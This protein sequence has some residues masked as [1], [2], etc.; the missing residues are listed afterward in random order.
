MPRRRKEM[1]VWI[2][3]ARTTKWTV[4]ID[5]TD[6]S[7]YILSGSFTRGLIGEDSRCEIELDNSGENY[8]DFFDIGD[9]IVFKMDFSNGSTVQWQGKVEGIEDG[10]T[11]LFKLKITGNHL[12]AELLDVTVTEEYANAKVSDILKD[13]INKYLN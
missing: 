1:F 12:T 8:T 10:L 7:D 9:D 4:T 2:P 13:L 5:N 3:P 6:V 11:N